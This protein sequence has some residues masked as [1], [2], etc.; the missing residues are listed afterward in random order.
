MSLYQKIENIKAQIIDTE[1]LLE[2][3]VDHPI[4]AE[5]LKEKLNELESELKSLSSE[6]YEAKVRL[7]FSG[8]A[9]VGSMGIKSTFLGKTLKPFQ[10]MVRTQAA[11]IRFG[12]VGKRGAPKKGIASD[13]YLTALPIG[14]FGVELSQIESED[15]F[16]AQDMTEAMKNVAKLI[17]DTSIDDNTFE[18]AIENTPKRN[19][20][21]LKNFLEELYD[22]NSMLKIECHDLGLEIKEPKVAEAYQRV[23]KTSDES[24][25]VF[26]TGILRGILLDSGKFEIQTISGKK[27]SGF[28]NPDLDEET[29]IEYDRKF[30]N[31]TCELHLQKHRTKFVTGKEKINYELLEIF[32]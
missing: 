13:L 6:S 17:Q 5:S 15:L 20:S 28:I 12:K 32:E 3:V 30:L 18:K 23:T 8:D 27:R 21:H 4:M 9:V 24:E 1:R 7:L 19:L 10:E 31:E 29:L 16:D 26:L 25:D 14:S 22:E 2:M 11:L